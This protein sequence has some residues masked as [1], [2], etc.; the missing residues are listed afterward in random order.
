MQLSD[1]HDG[2][3]VAIV[4]KQEQIEKGSIGY[5]QGYSTSRN[6]VLVKFANNV[7]VYCA[8]DSVIGILQ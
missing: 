8:L 1:M 3:L 5:N 6:K 7:E 2:Q 4:K